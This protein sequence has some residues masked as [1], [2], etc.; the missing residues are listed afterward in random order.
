MLNISH[1]ALQTSSRLSSTSF[2]GPHDL[3]SL[4][5]RLSGVVPTLSRGSLGLSDISGSEGLE[6][7]V[8]HSSCYS[9]LM[10]IPTLLYTFPGDAPHISTLITLHLHGSP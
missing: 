8:I 3:N 1:G 6:E 5:S 10:A 4:A 7:Q 9:L 2:A